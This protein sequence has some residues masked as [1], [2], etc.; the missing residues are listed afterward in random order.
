V[1]CSNWPGG[2]QTT[3]ASKCTMCNVL[4]FILDVVYYR[5]R[6]YITHRAHNDEQSQQCAH[7]DLIIRH[8]LAKTF[9]FE[10]FL[11][12]FHVTFVVSWSK[13]SIISFERTLWAMGQ[14]LL[15]DTFRFFHVRLLHRAY[16]S[17]LTLLITGQQVPSFGFA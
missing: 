6:D 1:D 17:I 13:E 16:H 3:T 7:N 8:Y 5:Q 10:L 14:L 2:F 11:S 12:K 15:N 9:L 4:F